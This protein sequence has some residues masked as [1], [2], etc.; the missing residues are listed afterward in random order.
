ME[1]SIIAGKFCRRIINPLFDGLTYNTS[2]HFAYCSHFSSPLRGSQKYYATR[3]ISAHIIR[4]I[5]LINSIKPLNKVYI[6]ILVTEHFINGVLG[7]SLNS[8]L[9]LKII[10]AKGWTILF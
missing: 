2:G 1:N 4:I 9:H 3:K 6:I 5:I 10:I 8:S 7:Q